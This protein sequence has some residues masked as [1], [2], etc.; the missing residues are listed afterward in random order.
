LDLKAEADLHFL[1]GIN[2]LVGHGWPY[3]AE[4]IEY[5]GWRFYAA[6]ALNNQNPWWIVMPDLSRY[7]Q[8]LSA[9]L[10]QGQP[11]NDVALYL[12]NSDAWA[13]FSGGR[14]HLIETLRDQ[15]GSDVM[16]QVLEAGFNLDF[17]DDDALRQV[18]RVENGVLRLGSGS[19]R[20]VILPGVERIPGATLQV[21]ADFA[22]S[23]GVLIAT[24]R[25]PSLAPGFLATDAEHD[26]IRDL[27]HGLF[28]G[29]SAPAHFVEDEKQLGNLISRQ[30]QADVALSTAAP[31]I[32]FVHRRTESADIYFV[33]NTGNSPVN[34]KATF[35]AQSRGAEWWDPISGQVS[36]A[37]TPAQTS[38]GVTVP[39][40]LA[41]YASTV[42]VVSG[43]SLPQRV[44]R[45]TPPVA[46][47]IDLSRDWRVSFG[48]GTQPTTM[49]R[50]Q[51]WTEDKNTRY[52]SG[53]ATYEKTVT[54]PENMIQPGLAIRL[55]FGEGQPIPPR[56]LR[57]GMQAWL[58][59]PVREAA[60]VYVNDQRAGAVWCP[61]FS[62]DVTAFLKAG[63][64]RV[65]VVVGNLAVNYMAGHSLPD[66]R[67]LNLRYGVRFE[68]QD[69]DKLQPVA[70]GLLGP[71]R[72]V[73]VVKT[74]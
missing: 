4:G 44:S 58:E 59:A 6:G 49:D 26:Q 14:V 43:R 36:K 56:N 5:P 54:I 9:L 55:D 64:N 23:G 73:G 31:D 67:L 34:V 39:L 41:P 3:T 61:P 71:I 68:A 27:S 30:L 18:G 32:G 12:P 29:K 48:Q 72:L 57:S 53:L 63:M 17:F 11:V 45:Q 40:S 28:E 21:L 1:Q 37:G 66:Y 60:V 10:R 2:Q 50:L 51:S 7:L 35:R 22:R 8:R 16:A 13:H 52:F 24:R 25:L 19:Y 15:V 42:L 46:P 69:L 74:Q 62:L 20:A 70:A 65:K 38:A 47:P 33:A